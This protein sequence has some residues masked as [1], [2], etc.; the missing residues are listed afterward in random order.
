MAKSSV[1]MTPVPDGLSLT[2]TFP[3][4]M[5]KVIEGNLIKRASW[6][7]EMSYGL[8]KDGW[9]M[10]Y[11]KGDFHTWK[12]NDGDMIADDWIVIREKN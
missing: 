1:P 10:I 3:E 11:I 2:M 6:T 8:L 7:S 4:A 5:K 9:L 12:V